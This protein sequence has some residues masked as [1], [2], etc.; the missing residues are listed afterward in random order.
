MLRARPI[1]RGR[2]RGTLLRNIEGQDGKDRFSWEQ[3]G[4]S[5]RCRG[6]GCD[7]AVSRRYCQADCFGFITRSTVGW[8]WAGVGW[9]G[10][11][12]ERIEPWPDLM[13]DP[14]VGPIAF[15]TIGFV[16]PSISHGE[17]TVLEVGILSAAVVSRQDNGTNRKASGREN[18]HG[19]TSNLITAERIALVVVITFATSSC[20][21]RACAGLCR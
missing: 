10:R 18:A 7:S 2:R 13:S 3:P 19:N 9:Y 12:W 17:E 6:L 8:R 16:A 1:I 21:S 5:P 14:G 11:W 20:R 4:H 15:R